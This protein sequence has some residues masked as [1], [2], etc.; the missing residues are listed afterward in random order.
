MAPSMPTSCSASATTYTSS[1]PET[2][3]NDGAATTPA[4][5]C[6]TS[7]KPTPSRSTRGQ[8]SSARHYTHDSNGGPALRPQGQTAP[9]IHF[10]PGRYGASM[11]G[12]ARRRPSLYQNI[13]GAS[14]AHVDHVLDEPHRTTANSAPIN[15]AP[16]ADS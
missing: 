15:D 8:H 16:H 3:G 5:C 2:P 9:P 10:L 12:S 6:S 13:P 11:F 1:P 14:V 4:R 7:N